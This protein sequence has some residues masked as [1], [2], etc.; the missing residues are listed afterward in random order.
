MKL[1]EILNINYDEVVLERFY[2]DWNDN[3]QDLA[4]RW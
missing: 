4:G 1:C 3:N 2:P